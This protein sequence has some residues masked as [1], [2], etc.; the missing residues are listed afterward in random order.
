MLRGSA[1]RISINQLWLGVAAAVAVIWPA[2]TLAQAPRYPVKPLRIVVPLP[3]AGSTDI[4]ARLVAQKFNEAWGQ[5]VI[6]DN[7]PGAGTVLGSELV[8]RA[9]P[10]GYTML[11]TSSS[12]ATSVSLYR[13]SFDPAKDLAPVGPVGQSFYVLAV[14][15]AFPANSVREFI[16]LAKAKPGQIL[17]ASAGTGTIT[18]LTVELFMAHAKISMLHVPFK[19]GAPALVAFLGG[20][21]QAIFSPIAEI[22]PHVRAGGK[23]RTLA[24]T[25]STR[26]AELPDVPTFTE[27]DLPGYEVVS[28]SGI[29]VP[30]GTP[31]TIVAQLN[32]GIN[33]MVQQPEARERLMS[34]GLVPVGGPP[35]ALGD[36]LKSEIARWAKVVKDAGIKLE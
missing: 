22:L 33:R 36:H 21:V 35:A 4:V 29:Y 10:D 27:S 3:P 15:P 25:N 2:A 6:V 12:L 16:A 32:A 28:W 18:H 30:A 9:A 23:V 13:M 26:L 14:H 17:Y 31:R 7:R 19:G 34:L 5:P 24:V 1:V 20:Q 11:L 8:A